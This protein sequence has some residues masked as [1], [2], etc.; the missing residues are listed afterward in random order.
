MTNE[1]S[2]VEY[3]QFIALNPGEPGQ[4]LKWDGKQYRWVNP[5]I[6]L[7][8]LEAEFGS[9]SNVRWLTEEEV[10][11]YDTDGNVL[12]CKCGKKASASL[13]GACHQIHFC[14]DCFYGDKNER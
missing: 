11:A 13:I 5:D 1:E 7:T 14:K 3:L 2:E 8:E 6:H 4:I 12:M 9:S 10:T